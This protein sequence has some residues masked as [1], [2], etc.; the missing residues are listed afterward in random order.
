MKKL[1]TCLLILGLL[2]T[3]VPWSVSAVADGTCGDGITWTLDAQGVLTFTGSGTMGTERPWNDYRD[4]I[5]SVVIGKGITEI[6]DYAFA[7]MQVTVA[8]IPDS[9]TKIGAGAFFGTALTEVYIPATVTDIGYGAFS[10]CLGLTAITVAEGNPIYRSVE[11]LLYQGDT[12]IRVPAGVK[13]V[14]LQGKLPEIAV[15]AF[16]GVTATVTAEEDPQKNFGGDLNWVIVPTT[17]PSLTAKYCTVSFEGAIQLN[18]YFEVNNLENPT[19]LGLLTFDR[20]PNMGDFSDAVDVIAGAVTD[21]TQYMVHTNGIPAKNLGDTVYFCIYAKLPDGSY[22]YSAINNYS[23]QTYAEGRLT[24]SDPA[25]VELV[26][27]MLDYGASAQAYF[28][29]RTQTL[30]NACMDGQGHVYGNAWTAERPA[31]VTLEGTEYR[32]CTHCGGGKQTRLTEKLTLTE[33]EVTS[34]SQIGQIAD[35]TLLDV[36]GLYVGVAE[37]GASSDKE[38]LLKDLHSDAIIAVRN[39][40]YGS[41]PEYGYEYGD[42]IRIQAT[43]KLDGTS[44]TPHKR[45]LDFS[46]ENGAIQS[47]IVSVGNEVTY[48]LNNTV[49]VDSWA[50]MQALFAVGSIA[51]YTYVEITAPLYVNRYDGTDGVSV[52]RI[53]GNGAATGVSS[54]R[55]D[56]KRTVSL[57][58]NVM[59]RNLGT[60][61]MSLLFDSVPQTGSY[62]GYALS[63][64]MIALYTGANGYYYQLTVLDSSWLSFQ[65]FDNY[66]VVTA[67]ADAYL[68][69]GSQIQYDQTQS[70]RNINASPEE[71]SAANTLYLDCSSY[72]NAVYFEAFGVNALPYTLQEKRP[73]TAAFTTYAQENAGVAVDAIGY[74]ENG[75]YTTSAQISAVLKEVREQLQVGDLLVYRHGETDATAGHVYIY[76]G[77]GLFN[78]CT[79]SS[80][81]YADD[82]SQSHD[83][84]TSAEKTIGAVQSISAEEIFTNTTGTRY[85][86]KVTDAD[87]VYNFSLL[88]PMARGLTPTEESKKRMKAKAV[89]ME[90]SVSKVS[91]AVGETLRYTVTLTNYGDA[92]RQ[93]SLEE[94]LGGNVTYLSGTAGITCANGK[95]NWRGTIPADTTLTVFYDL[96]IDGGA[97]VV[98]NTA[99]NGVELDQLTTTVSGC[100]DAQLASV[101]ALAKQYAAQ[102]KTFAE[103]LSMAKALYREALG[104]EIFGE[105][106]ALTLLSSIIDTKNDTC[107]DVPMLVPHLYGGLDIKSGMV[108][109]NQRTRL[110]RPENLAVGDVTVAEYDGIS[111]VFVYM[112][113]SSLVQLSSTD[114]VCKQVT[115]SGNIYASDDIFVTFTAYDC[116]A[117]LRPSMAV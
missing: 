78:H 98:S 18:V 29:Y 101:A 111:T 42:H 116:F 20:Y 39:V 63:G 64:S 58:D 91:A 7:R 99:V 61:W 44:N 38:L 112:G 50:Q 13:Q 40:P 65:N 9:V 12:L 25:V 90:K 110:V 48:D 1:I 108:Y 72:V 69:Q 106:T 115:G 104:I 102:G 34:V 74:W 49:K 68:Q 36:E 59:E 3:M 81:A 95:L 4:R 66:D 22:V 70:R 113:G 28:N 76:M 86:F 85:L 15:D 82:P 107:Y 62:P 37:E 21:G 51:E 14:T 79:G 105:D 77:N 96:R 31:S 60:D 83:K 10:N 16:R 53:H 100:T 117:V 87:S 43:V 23:P 17:E 46:T 84:A 52:S 32:K 94:T 11:G 103:P 45:Y 35:S 73:S 47:T 8:S 67:V 27:S 75:D 26:R 33:P 114:G 24:N 55:T 88:R 93:I 89:D 19:E 5:Y 80:F 97:L 54:I 56:G 109:D 6:C 92:T 41:F 57:R 30:M 2:A 71:A